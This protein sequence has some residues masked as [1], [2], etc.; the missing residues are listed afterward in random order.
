MLTELEPMLWA[1]GDTH[2]RDEPELERLFGDGEIDLAMSYNPNFVDV[3][4]GRGVFPETARP[5]VFADGTLQN[6]SFVA[7]PANASSREGAQVVANLML[8]PELQAAKRDDVGIPSVLDHETLARASDQ[9]GPT[10]DEHRLT[11]FGTPLAELPAAEVPRLDR[12]WQRE[13]L[14]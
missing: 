5:Y 2:P 1:G 9:L 7:I 11:N 12:R 4:V 14:G 10:R 8:S 3:A 6:V 13:V